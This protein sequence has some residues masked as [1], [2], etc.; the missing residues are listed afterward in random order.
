M[1]VGPETP[2][3][4]V[5]A[6]QRIQQCRVQIWQD[7]FKYMLFLFPVAISHHF[8]MIF[9]QGLNLFYWRTFSGCHQLKKFPKTQQKCRLSLL[10][11][12]L[13]GVDQMHQPL[14]ISPAVRCQPARC[15]KKGVGQR[16]ASHSFSMSFLLPSCN[17]GINVCQRG[18]KSMLKTFGKGWT[19]SIYAI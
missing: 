16:S 12:F 13:V 9:F 1:V 10:W 7:L 5:E 6:N 4:V 17:R 3:E 15:G 11:V 18:N 14:L 2:A 8:A 19:F